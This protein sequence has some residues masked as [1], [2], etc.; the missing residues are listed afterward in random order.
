MD[1]LDLSYLMKNPLVL[2]LIGCYLLVNQGCKKQL[3]YTAFIHCNII[4]GTGSEIKH[5]QT[6][7]LRSNIIYDF[8]PELNIPQKCRVINASGKT[9]IPGLIDMHGHLYALGSSQIVAYPKLYLSGGVTTI[10]SP[11]EFEPEKVIELRDKINNH[12]TVGPTIFTAGSY[13]DTYPSSIFWIEACKDTNE[14]LNKF[15]KWKDRIDAVKVYSNTS[16]EQFKVIKR[17][18]QGSGFLI[19]GH[20]G[21]L[22][23]KSAIELGINGF[24]HGIFAIPEFNFEKDKTY[25]ILA[26]LDLSNEKVQSLIKLI[27]QHNVYCDPTIVTAESHLLSFSPVVNDIDEFLSTEIIN[28]I[29]SFT[30]NK[31][32]TTYL[33]EAIKKQMAFC[34]LLYDCG[35]ILVT[36]TDPVNPKLL[37]GYA[38]KREMEI[39][40]ESGI[41]P[42]EV[43][44]IAT[45]NGANSLRIADKVGS[46][47]KGKIADLVLIDGNPVDDFKSIWKVEKVIK[48]G[49]IFIPEKLRKSVLHTIIAGKY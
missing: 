19:T 43:I 41:T 34:K 33:N 13:F 36:G 10:F 28:K 17:L 27:V 2:I 38:I 24:E 14:V 44:K 3:E 45:S 39:F 18:A 48:N 49:Q 25:K 12:E 8:G 6:L 42:T 1:Y 5:D 22:K 37:P 4:D 26:E 31:T 11:G 9:F 15:A 21:S 16:E 7:I 46:I 30:L 20:L 32:S 29:P 23:L 35:G 47:E 40:H